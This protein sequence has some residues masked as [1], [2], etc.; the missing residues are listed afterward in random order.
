MSIIRG[1]KHHFEIKQT[2]SAA[3]VTGKRDLGGNQKCSRVS[4]AASL[5]LVAL[6]L[7]GVAPGA[8]AQI[9]TPAMT[10]SE[11][12]TPVTEFRLDN[13]IRVI[14][15]PDHRVP[16]VTHMV[17][18]AVGAADEGPD[19]HGVA[20]YLEHMMFKGTATYPKGQFDRFVMSR[21]GA[22]N[23]STS[24]EYT[25]YYQRLPKPALPQI[26]AMEA[27]RMVNL[28]INDEDVA[29]ERAV[30]LE[31]FHRKEL[32]VSF[33]LEKKVGVALHGNDPRSRTT[34]G[35]EA[36]IKVLNGVTAQRFYERFYGPS[37]ATVV[38]AGDVTEAEVRTL[39]AQT[40]GKVASRSGLGTHVKPTMDATGPSVRVESSHERATAVGVKR[41]YVV[42]ATEKLSI[43][44]LNAAN[45]LEYIAGNGSTSRLHRRL[46]NEQGVATGVGC[47]YAYNQ[48]V[49]TF[50]CYAN[51]RVGITVPQLEA[52]FDKALDELAGN[53]V[54]DEEFD[55]IKGR[56]LATSAYRR[57]NV[58]SRAQSYASSLSVGML[59][60]DVDDFEKIV[61]SLTRADI[62][63]MAGQILVGTRQVS[64]VLT[65][66]S[67]VAAAATATSAN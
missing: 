4:L 17:W 49:S 53:G 30:V 8:Q 34:I 14:V 66:K 60:A 38:V 62:D 56:I 57:D 13:G 5:A 1:Q 63:R 43:K 21:G 19:E 33:D 35:T 29:S 64:G 41:V 24:M 45:V 46:V 6:G 23:A 20:H 65:P 3:S 47:N 42:P 59:I 26:M 40:Y 36:E 25:N 22:H 37:N 61:E 67:P 54:T 52:A 16:V 2:A 50:D 48:T 9:A 11:K 12:A 10:K 55:E 44:Q 28:K 51:G 15:I 31:E 18:Y 32:I 39:T 7:A 27:D 58:Y